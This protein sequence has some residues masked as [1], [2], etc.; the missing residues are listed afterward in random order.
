[1]KRW[2]VAVSKDRV[3]VGHY[4]INRKTE[5]EN[6]GSIDERFWRLPPRLGNDL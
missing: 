4:D 5:I 1:M 2:N 6:S 3:R